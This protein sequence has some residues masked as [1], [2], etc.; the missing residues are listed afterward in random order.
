MVETSWLEANSQ[1]QREMFNYGGFYR[2][3]P[4]VH[5]VK[6]EREDKWLYY[7]DRG[8]R[9][10]RNEVTLMR[11]KKR[12]TLI[13]AYLD[14]G[15]V[16]AVWNEPTPTE[17]FETPYFIFNINAENIDIDTLHD[18]WVLF[19]DWY[20]GRIE[21]VYCMAQV[22]CRRGGPIFTARDWETFEW[23][24]SIPCVSPTH[25]ERERTEAE[26]IR[27]VLE[28]TLEY[29]GIAREWAQSELVD[30]DNNEESD[31]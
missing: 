25:A 20:C 17:H 3:I 5:C 13:P 9:D 21:V 19:E 11:I 2:V 27:Q 10:Q 1:T 23:V 7:V 31:L 26:M 12:D 15:E 29:G 16:V 14:T 8:V 30:T 24:T 4:S 28:M 6:R 22:K 18:Q